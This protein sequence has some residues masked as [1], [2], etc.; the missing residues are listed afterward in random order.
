MV[1]WRT[2]SIG[3]STKL[4]SQREYKDQTVPAVVILGVIDITYLFL[5][6]SRRDGRRSESAGKMQSTN[7]TRRALS[8]AKKNAHEKIDA[9]TGEDEEPADG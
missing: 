7:K 3:P 1:E 8:S 9:K 5:R 2:H 6:E 4:L